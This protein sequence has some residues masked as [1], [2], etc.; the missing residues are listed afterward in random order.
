MKSRLEN[1][2]RA[3]Y[4]GRI[5]VHLGPVK[6][7][8]SYKKAKCHVQQYSYTSIQKSTMPL[9]V[10]PLPNIGLELYQ[11]GVHKRAKKIV[12]VANSC[13]KWLNNRIKFSK[14]SGCSTVGSSDASDT[15]DP[16]FV[17]SHWQFLFTVNF[18]KKTKIKKKEAENC[19]IFLNQVLQSTHQNL[20][21]W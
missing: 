16:R 20:V 21:V 11:L 17:S 3:H 5:F 19:P 10:H 7:T 6:K 12:W 15:T 1:N 4:W 14:G 9:K 18:F 8:W 2:L 13:E